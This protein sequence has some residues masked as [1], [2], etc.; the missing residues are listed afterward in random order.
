MLECKIEAV[1]KQGTQYLAMLSFYDSDNPGVEVLTPQQIAC[2]DLN[3]FSIKVHKLLNQFQDVVD[4]RIQT[5]KAA[6]ETRLQAILAERRQ[7]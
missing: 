2:T 5:V 3:E 7:A 4:G 6:A 1:E